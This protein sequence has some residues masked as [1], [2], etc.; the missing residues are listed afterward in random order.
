MTDI[1]DPKVDVNACYCFD[2]SE[3][4]KPDYKMTSAIIEWLQEN[5]EN[6]LDDEDN[7]I[8]G[9][10]NTGFNEETLRSFGKRPVCDVYLDRVEYKSDFDDHIPEKA[11]TFL[12][13]HMKGANN[14]TYEKS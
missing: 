3:K 10:V 9:K 11:F 2:I 14:A 12:L 13:F 7:Q 4:T 1:D 5:M 6:L 8:F